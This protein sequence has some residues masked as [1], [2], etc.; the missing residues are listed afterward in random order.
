MKKRTLSL[1]V[2]MVLLAASAGFSQAV[3]MGN[4]GN[5]YPLINKGITEEVPDIIKTLDRYQM[6]EE[7]EMDKLHGEFFP[8]IDQVKWAIISQEIQSILGS[9]KIPVFPK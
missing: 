9:V 5:E 3:E 6:I 8:W 1:V 7:S 2:G 4:R